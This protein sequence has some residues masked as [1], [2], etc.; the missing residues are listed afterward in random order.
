[1]R[2]SA[3]AGPDISFKQ[4]YYTATGYACGSGRSDVKCVRDDHAQVL[5]RYLLKIHRL[6]I[7]V[8]T[9]VDLN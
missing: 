3:L 5:W 1:M 9:V 6:S 2:I 7:R 8:S 4:A